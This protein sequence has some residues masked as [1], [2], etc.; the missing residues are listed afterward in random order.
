MTDCYEEIKYVAEYIL[1]FVNETILKYEE[2]PSNLVPHI[3][4]IYLNPSYMKNI[5]LKL[6]YERLNMIL[7]DNINQIVVFLLL[8][9]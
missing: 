6:K 2:K 4:V 1:Q 8:F 7:F 3:F 9:Y 5:K